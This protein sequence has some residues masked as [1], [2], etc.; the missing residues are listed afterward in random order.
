[1]IRLYLLM[2]ALFWLTIALDGLWNHKYTRS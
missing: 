1:M 2:H